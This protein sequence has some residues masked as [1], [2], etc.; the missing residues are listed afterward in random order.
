VSARLIR[1]ECGGYVADTPG[2][3]DVGLGDVEPHTLPGCFPEFRPYL[4]QC[5]FRDCTHLHEPGCVVRS[6]VD[7]EEI[8]ARRYRSYATILEELTSG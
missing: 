6:A 3:S 2:F 8:S 7:G 4:G 5:R 1:L